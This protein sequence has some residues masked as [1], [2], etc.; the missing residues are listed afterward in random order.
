MKLVTYTAGGDPRLGSRT[1]QGEIVDLNQGYYAYLRSQ[2]HSAPA[3]LA[4]AMIP[5]EMVAFLEGGDQAVEIART[6]VRFVKDQSTAETPLRGQW[7]ATVVFDERDV[8][9]LAPVLRPPKIIGIGLNYRDHAEEQGAKVP[10]VPLIFAKFATSIIGP[11][12]PIIYPKITEQLDYEAELA[13]IIGKGGKNI[14]ADQAYEHIAGYCVF[15]DVTSRDIQLSDRQWVRGKTGDT[16]A[17]IGP[18]LVTRDE[19]AEPGNLKIRLWLND[20]LVQDSNTNQLI[21]DIPYLV[22]FL[23]DAF[24]LEP[25]DIVA[26]GTPSGVGFARKPPVF[27][28]VGDRVK[29]E[30]E[31]LGTLENPIVAA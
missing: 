7:R 17:P 5:P 21:F 15:N 1:Q 16:L 8:R 25:G 2:G 13:F 30:V 22:S 4:D 26:T 14:P 12:E 11:G 19:V 28:Q 29:V 18:Y 27:L 3:R 9:L 10:K 24:T 31:G 20:E 6:V 23:S